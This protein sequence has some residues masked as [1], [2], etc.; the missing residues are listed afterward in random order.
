MRH[1][2]APV[3]LSIPGIGAR[4]GA[5]IL[6]EIGDVARF[7]TPGHLAAYA[8]WPCAVTANEILNGVWPKK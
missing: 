8:G 7:P 3:L 5:R 1:R 6:T 2:Q 4:T